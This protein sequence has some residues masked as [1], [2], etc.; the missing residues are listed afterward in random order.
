MKSFTTSAIWCCCS[1]SHTVYSFDAIK[2]LHLLV[3]Q[4]DWGLSVLRTAKTD[5]SRTAPLRN[6]PSKKSYVVFF[7]VVS[8]SVSKNTDTIFY[9]T[10][11]NRHKLSSLTTSTTY[12]HTTYVQIHAKKKR[13]TCSN[14]KKQRKAEKTF[15]YSFHRLEHIGLISGAFYHTHCHCHVL[16]GLQSKRE[17]VNLH[18]THLETPTSMT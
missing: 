17:L 16:V 18:L 14:I 9:H 11:L 7:V 12:T 6:L 15:F 3:V 5:L 4:V 10:F 13:N 8:S 2:S 1:C